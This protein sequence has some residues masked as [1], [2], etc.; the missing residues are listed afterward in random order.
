MPSANTQGV[1][2]GSSGTGP[3]GM[4]RCPRSLIDLLA[5]VPSG[6]TYD[7]LTTCGATSASYRTNRSKL[8]CMRRLLV[9]ALVL[10]ASA[11]FIPRN[12]VPTVADPAPV[13]TAQEDSSWEVRALR[14]SR[15]SRSAHRA[16]PHATPTPRK[17]VVQKKITRQHKVARRLGT[18]S[19]ATVPS[20]VWLRLRICE[21]GNNYANKSNPLYRGAYQFSYGTWHGLGYPGDPADAAPDVQD[22]AARRLQKR[23]GWSPWPA[24]SRKLGLR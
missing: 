3:R 24:C 13:V 7:L 22:E 12:V 5:C 6:G 19:D 23:D 9:A 20:S 2:C 15:A 4:T 10:V 1:C 11:T 14:S 17:P 21:S 8:D 18:A 16:A